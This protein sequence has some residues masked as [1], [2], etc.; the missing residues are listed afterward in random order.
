MNHIS[1]I[2]ATITLIAIIIGSS[3]QWL[4]VWF[5]AMDQRKAIRVMVQP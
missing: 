3:G 2:S 1:S 4:G 5:T